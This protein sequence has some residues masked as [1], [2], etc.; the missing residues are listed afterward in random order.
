MARL[1]CLGHSVGR[2]LGE[3][4]RPHSGLT[5]CPEHS[6][7]NGVQTNNLRCYGDRNTR[8]LW[9]QKTHDAGEKPKLLINAA[10]A[11]C[12]GGDRWRTQVFGRGC[13]LPPC[14]HPLSWGIVCSQKLWSDLCCARQP[15]AHMWRTAS[16]WV[17]TLAQ[18][19]SCSRMLCS[20]RYALQPNIG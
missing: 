1:L 12:R 11:T 20:G 18:S 10:R 7:A 9:K 3:H 16:S 19:A 8:T 14:I 4:S 2:V 5:F 6:S 13:V 15:I 17:S